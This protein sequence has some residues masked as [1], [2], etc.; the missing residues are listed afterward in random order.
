MLQGSVCTIF[1]DS[2]VVGLVE[3][4]T[5]IHPQTGRLYDEIKETH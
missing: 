5:N 4:E 1:Q 3:S 2:F